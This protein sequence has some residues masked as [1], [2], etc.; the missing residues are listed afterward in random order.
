MMNSNKFEWVVNE[1]NLK[2]A[3]ELAQEF[4]ENY[5]IKNYQKDYK[6]K[7]FN[8]KLSEWITLDNRLGKDIPLQIKKAIFLGRLDKLSDVIIIKPS[9][10]SFVVPLKQSLKITLDRFNQN[11]WIAFFTLVMQ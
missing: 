4:K 1:V 9:V 2:F 8:I 6:N 10:Y 7:F 11:L 3:K 5:L